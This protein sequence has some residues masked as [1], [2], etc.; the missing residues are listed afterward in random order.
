[1]ISSY[2]VSILRES[3]AVFGGAGFPYGSQIEESWHFQS[4]ASER[5]TECSLSAKIWQGLNYA[6]EK[7]GP[8]HLHSMLYIFFL[9]VLVMPQQ[10]SLPKY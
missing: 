10:S 3:F 2:S 9:C 1:M 8:Y 5:Q 4:S 7:G 6:E